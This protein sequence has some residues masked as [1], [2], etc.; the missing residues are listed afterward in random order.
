MIQFNLDTNGPREPLPKYW[1][2]CVGSCHA[3][4]ALR[5]DWRQML[6][7]CQRELGF[8]YVRFHGLF[9]DDMSVVLQNTFTK[10]MR[11][12]FA[13]IDK[14]FDFLLSINMKP[15]V[16]L[17]FMP[18]ALASGKTTIFHYKGNTSPPASQ[19][20]W[21]W[22]IREF[23]RHLFARYGRDEVRQWFFEVWNE[24]NMGGAGSPFGFWSGSM[25][26]YFELYRTTAETLKAED[27]FLRVGGPATSNN[28]WVPEMVAFCRENGVPIDFISTHHYPTD[29]VLGFG[30]EDSANFQKPPIDLNDTAS[31]QK[32]F[33]D[34]EELA[35]KAKEY[36]VFQ[37]TLWE[38]V[39]R[40]VLTAM[41]RRVAEQAGELPVYYTEWG[42][43][44]GLPSDGPFGASFIPKTVL[45]SRGLAAGY[46]FWTFSDIVEES[47]QDP[48]AFHGGFGLLTQHGIPKAPYRAFQLLHGLGDTMYS[49]TMTAGTVDGYAFEKPESGAVQLLL[50]NHQ[51]LLHEVDEEEIRVDLA[52]IGPLLD[53]DVIRI[54]ET[55]ANALGLWERMGSPDYLDAAQVLRL[56]AESELCREPIEFTASGS[57]ASL[58]LRLPP[59]GVALVTL[60]RKPGK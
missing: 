22:L 3:T 5:E 29:V 45:D 41:D 11:L 18:E 56:Q 20:Q 8:R 26:D 25:E 23:V 38:Q 55:H 48:R 57:A 42:S 53:A 12:S 35:K 21:A 4:T 59:M 52:G 10:A 24:P 15:F 14:L 6:T 1:E 2:L 31:L 51:S 40:G 32:L 43:L 30:V 58:T 39:D 13:N 28:A 60:Y 33:A 27:P 9:C 7:R 47:G 34:P 16:E 49:R 17:G 37:E 36:S 46:S 50:V 44:A 54:D 19:E